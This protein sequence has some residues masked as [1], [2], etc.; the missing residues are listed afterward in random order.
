MMLYTVVT[1]VIGVFLWFEVLQDKYN[2]HQD[3]H[4]PGQYDGQHKAGN[5]LA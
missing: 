5:K 1:A 4:Q 2:G 3:E